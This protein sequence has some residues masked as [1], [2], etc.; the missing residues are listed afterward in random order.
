MK[1]FEHAMYP[2]IR[3]AED[4]A[5]QLPELN[6]SAL[7]IAWSMGG[8]VALELFKKYPEKVRGLFLLASSPVF[9]ASDIFPE[10]KSADTVAALRTGIG[11]DDPAALMQFQRQ[12]FGPKEIKDGHLAKFR[13]EIAPKIRLEKKQ[14]LKALDFISV[15]KPSPIPDAY[16]LP[17]LI[18]HGTGDLV[19]DYHATAA[20]QRL[21]PHADVRLYD[22]GH[23]LPLTRIEEI[24]QEIENFVI[25][26]DR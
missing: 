4:G 24:M 6:N 11:S 16:H 5:L 7:I 9:I 3:L 17:V 20:W 2:T 15:Y 13:R 26:H 18:M 8:M 25:R 10:G 19:I 23:A 1:R 22:T 14:L 12:L 21:F